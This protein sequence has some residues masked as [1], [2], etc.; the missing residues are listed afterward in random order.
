MPRPSLAWSYFNKAVGESGDDPQAECVLCGV[1][2]ANCNT[3]NLL[4]HLRE[5]HPSIENIGRTNG[6]SI[7]KEV[8]DELNDDDDDDDDGDGDDGDNEDE[9]TED[10]DNEVTSVVKPRGRSA[11]WNCYE[12][13]DDSGAI[14]KLCGKFIKQ[15]KQTFILE[16]CQAVCFC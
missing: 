12:R 4:R 13:T 3:S 1:W 7:K 15:V 8:V 11:V 16:Q 6:N 5:K 14:C 9:T 2:L 10:I